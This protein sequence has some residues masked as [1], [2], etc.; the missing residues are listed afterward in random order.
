MTI[1]RL[2]FRFARQALQQWKDETHVLFHKLLSYQLDI[3]KKRAK[4]KNVARETCRHGKDL[5]AQKT[6]KESNIFG[7]TL[8][9]ARH[10]DNLDPWNIDTSYYWVSVRDRLLWQTNQRRTPPFSILGWCPTGTKHISGTESLSLFLVWHIKS[11]RIWE[12]MPRVYFL[13]AKK[14][15]SEETKGEKDGMRSV[16]L[17][18]D[19]SD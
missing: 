14:T 13:S 10:N 18:Q 2:R 11:R 15:T 8:F 19:G 7:L 4:K 12:R 6:H 1:V 3:E 16:D 17:V 5:I 9:C